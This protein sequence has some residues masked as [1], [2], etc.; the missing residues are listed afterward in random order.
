MPST[1]ALPRALFMFTALLSGLACALFRSEPPVQPATPTA[2]RQIDRP[3][4]DRPADFTVSYTWAEGS[5]PPPYHYTYTIDV[6][7]DGT[8]TLTYTPDYA[9]PDVPVWTET[10]SLTDDQLADLYGAVNLDGLFTTDWFSQDGPP[11][12]GS[13]FWLSATANGVDVQV[14]AYVIPAQRPFADGLAASMNAL[15]AP[16]TW[17]ALEAQRQQYITE[18]SQ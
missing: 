14:P 2:A 7:A 12:G 3:S 17:D 1:H 6:A 15:I 5:L 18:H 9:G 11:V 16:A 10:V 13:S 4:A 8:V